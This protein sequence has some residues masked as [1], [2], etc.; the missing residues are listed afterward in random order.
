MPEKDTTSTAA[1]V[2]STLR[3]HTDPLNQRSE[4]IASASTSLAAQEKSVVQ[5][6]QKL[7]R[8][9][10]ELEEI[11]GKSVA[12][13]KEMGD[14]QNW[15]EYVFREISIVEETLKLAEEQRDEVQ[16]AGENRSQ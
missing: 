6:T 15:A 2:N 1:L 7:S 8:Q 5:N 13:L 16:E 10:D 11:V 14:L 9:A 12:Q 4:A 3:L